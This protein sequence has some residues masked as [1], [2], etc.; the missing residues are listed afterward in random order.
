MRSTER[1]GDR[2][3]AYA[4]HRPVVS[5]ARRRRAGRSGRS[6]G[7]TVADVGAGTGISSR[8]FADRGARVVADRAERRD[9]RGRRPHPRVE[10]YDG[11]ADRTALPDAERRPCHRLPGVSLV[12]DAACDDASCAAIARRRVAILQY[13]RDERDAFTKAYGDDRAC[14]RARRYRGTARAAL[15]TFETFPNARVVARDGSV[16][17]SARS[18]RPARAR[19]FGVVPAECGPGAAALQRDLTRGLRTSPARR[20]GR[21]SRW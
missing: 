6:G 1:F 9:A 18:R 16:A 17:A 2:A 13:E 20:Y 21:L 11:T 3:Q 15:A 7:L 5:R 8:L 4:A 14:L 10:W 12:R 19:R